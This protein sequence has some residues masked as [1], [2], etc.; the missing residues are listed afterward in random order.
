MV[1]IYFRLL[2]PVEADVD[3]RPVELGHARQRCVLVALLMDAGRVVPVDVLLDRVWAGRLPRNA[4]AAVSGYVSRLRHVFPGGVLARAPGG[5]RLDVDPMAVDLHRF[6][7]LSTRAG[8]DSEAGE[9][10]LTEALRLWRGDA[11]ADLETPWLNEIRAVLDAERHAAELAR[12]DLALARGGHAALLAEL[13]ARVAAHPFD[14]RLVGQFLLAL[15][16]CGRLADAL[17]RYEETRRRLAEELGTDPGS[18]L[19]ALHQRMLTADPT[20]GETATSTG[21]LVPRQLPV[22]PRSFAGRARELA[23]LDAL[24]ATTPSTVVISAVSGTPGV[25]KTALALHWAHRVAEKFGDGQLY[26]NLRGFDRSGSVMSPAEAVRIFLDAL[27]VPPHRIPV[28]LEA[29]TALY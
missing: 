1:A 13:S 5:Y 28:S 12:N 17:R 25:G 4:R 8:G 2:G 19:Q 22:A 21:R 24:L 29:K 20:L 14:E 11:F 6:R 9:A 10:L 18:A 23:N 27:A 7:Y 15:Y 26:V 3:G 16:R